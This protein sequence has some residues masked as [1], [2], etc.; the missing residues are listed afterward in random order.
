MS[1]DTQLVVFGEEPQ[2]PHPSAYG[3]AGSPALLNLRAYLE[4]PLRRPFLVLVPFGLILAA[5]IALG[6][7]LPKMF[8]SATLILVESEKMPDSFVRSMAT[9]TTHKRLG[10]IK[11]E[12][13]S[14]T[15]LQMV[16]EEL[17]PYPEIQSQTAAIEAMREATEINVKG[18]D[19]FSIEYVHRDARKAQQVTAR[20]ATLFI[21]ES[22]KARE[23]QVEEAY[24]F[25]DSQVRDARREL[26]VK[27]ASLRAYKEKHMGNLPEQTGANLA[28]LQMLQQE[29]QA[30]E[31]SLRDANQRQDLLEKGL[32]E[33]RTT[34]GSSAATA[35]EGSTDLTVLRG[36]LLA[37]RGRYTEEHPDVQ[38]LKA[39]IA[40]LER[41]YADV[42]AGV[43]A[44]S[45]D[46]SV[47]AARGQFERLRFEV[48]GLE[49]RRA[50]LERR[51]D[52]FRARVEQAP[53]TEQ[54]LATL[55]RD[56]QKLNENYLTLLNKKLDAQMAAKL[57]KRWK[58]EHFSILDP[59]H[60]P[61]R[62]YSPNR[63]LYLS[64]GLFLGL[65]VG[66]GAA[67]SREFLD[68]TVKD[69]EDLQTLVPFPV[70][71]TIPHVAQVEAASRALLRAR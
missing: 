18:N 53:R 1:K 71:A 65:V 23:Q 32:A 20:L 44:P 15:R 42:A 34:P 49:S 36:Q 50:E 51:I 52:T 8:R 62:P 6:L 14:R 29:L 3:S 54:E 2:A 46:P 12:I 39:R 33:P 63:P 45:V 5:S 17:N 43:K 26:E 7:F 25:L 60:L 61:E 57:E 9:E 4:A 13:L 21:E 35:S 28:T 55:T 24:E 10:T 41:Q 37:L 67:V 31:T 30:V 70:L 47:A 22:T 40:R 58:G 27:D 11:Q 16:I 68:G 59:A 38:N 69:V 56:Y 19:A 66:V 48:K 64:V